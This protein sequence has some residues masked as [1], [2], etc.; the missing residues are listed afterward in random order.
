M[1]CDIARLGSMAYAVPANAAKQAIKPGA[2]RVERSAQHCRARRS[3]EIFELLN[4]HLDVMM[5]RTPF[6]VEHIQVHTDRLAA[7]RRNPGCKDVSGNNIRF[8]LRRRTTNRR[9]GHGS[10]FPN[11]RIGE[12]P[13]WRYEAHNVSRNVIRL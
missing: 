13:H 12:G 6:V 11:K 8:T 10:R 1:Y 5:Q 3:R 2:A 9:E 7:G 4:D